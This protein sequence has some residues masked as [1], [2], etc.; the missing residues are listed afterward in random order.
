MDCCG[1][2]QRAFNDPN[3]FYS[4]HYY[5]PMV[6]THQGANW[7]SK[8]YREFL[9]GIAYPP[10]QQDEKETLECIHDKIV[11]SVSDPDQA[12][13]GHRQLKGVRR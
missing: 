11:A 4:F 2:I 8:R 10:A 6:V 1:S 9:S 5:D 13:N 3:I 12:K 7:G